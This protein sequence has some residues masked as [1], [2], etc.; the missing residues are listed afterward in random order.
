MTN[1]QRQKLLDKE[2]YLASEI[3]RKDLSG[4]MPYCNFCA[5]VTNYQACTATQEQ[6]E[7]ECLCA[8]AYD[9]GISDVKKRNA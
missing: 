4:E 2:K 9:R 8:K 6:R 7:S 1:K 3:K 5:C